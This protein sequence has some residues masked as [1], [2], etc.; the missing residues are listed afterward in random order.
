MQTTGAIKT[1]SVEAAFRNGRRALSRVATSITK[2]VTTAE[3]IVQQAF[4]RACES[5][6][7]LS[8]Q[9]MQRWLATVLKRLAIDEVRKDIVRARS[10]NAVRFPTELAPAGTPSD[11]VDGLQAA[12]AT[13]DRGTQELVELWC[14]GASYASIARTLEI[15]LGTVATRLMR[16]KKRCGAT[17]RKTR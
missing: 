3:H 10:A 9:E 16:A 12:L 7:T 5:R 8:A 6:L 13:L 14:A 4:L 2:D 15:P 1:V 11:V 17:L